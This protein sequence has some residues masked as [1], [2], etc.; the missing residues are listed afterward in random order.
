V[1]DDKDE[2]C[3]QQLAGKNTTNL[4]NHLSRIHKEEYKKLCELENEKA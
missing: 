4:K 3:G 2:P 1:N